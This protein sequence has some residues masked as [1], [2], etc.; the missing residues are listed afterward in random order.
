M[1]HTLPQLLPHC[2]HS[3][4]CDSCRDREGGRVFRAGVLRRQGIEDVDV[5]FDCP[6]GKKWKSRGLGD[7]IAKI[8]KAIGIKPCGGCKK[9]QARLNKLLSYKR[10]NRE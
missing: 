9:R 4:F 1:T 8:T 6:K 10:A 5:D 3:H 2:N 7:T